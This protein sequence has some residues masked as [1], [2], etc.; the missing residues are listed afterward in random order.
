M[1]RAMR[2]SMEADL[3][4][5]EALAGQADE[6]LGPGRGP[7]RAETAVDGEGNVAAA[8]VAGGAATE[9]LAVAFVDDQWLADIFG[10][11]DSGL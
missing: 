7:S 3:A 5:A 10:P 9:D 2:A 6:G 8:A 4:A 11:W 1:M